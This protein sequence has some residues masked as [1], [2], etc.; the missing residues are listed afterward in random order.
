MPIH[1]I[2]IAINPGCTGSIVYDSLRVGGAK[3]PTSYAKETFKAPPVGFV[4][5]P[6]VPIFKVCGSVLRS[7][8]GVRMKE[9]GSEWQ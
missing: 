1:K 4:G 7:E 6:T 9:W 8:G 3:I 5:T 2:E